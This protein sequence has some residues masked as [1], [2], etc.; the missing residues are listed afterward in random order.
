MSTAADDY[1]TL[2]SIHALHEESDQRLPR[3]DH[4]RRISIHALHE[5]SDPQALLDGQP[6]KTISIHA[7]HEES[8]ELSQAR[9]SAHGHFNPRS[10]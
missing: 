3:C 4:I 10:P 7:L 9:Q 1:A 2:I 8:D 6:K 5:E